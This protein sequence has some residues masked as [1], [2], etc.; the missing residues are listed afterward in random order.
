LE[1]PTPTQAEQDLVV[2]GLRSGYY[3]CFF[4]MH[5]LTPAV[6]ETLGRLLTDTNADP[7]VQLAAALA[8]LAQQERYLALE[9]NGTR[10]NIGVKYGLLIAQLALSLTGKDREHIL[11]ELVELLA[12]RVA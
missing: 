12:L 1:K 7:P 5:V 2:A 11:T 10:Y 3:L 9:V 8:T 6:M 4:G